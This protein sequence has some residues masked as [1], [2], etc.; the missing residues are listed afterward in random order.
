MK[1]ASPLVLGAALALVSPA[2]WAEPVS[3]SASAAV[4]LIPFDE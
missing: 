2:T 1:L 4:T 3:V